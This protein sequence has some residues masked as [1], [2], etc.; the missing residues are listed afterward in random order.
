M[1]QRIKEIIQFT[2]DKFG[3]EDYYLQS[4]SLNRHV[5]I[6]NETEYTLCMEWFPQHT[7][8]VEEGN[9]PDGAAMIEIDVNS[10]KIKSATF[11]NGKTYAKDGIAFT[12]PYVSDM[13]IWIEKEQ[14]ITYGTQFETCKEEREVILFTECLKGLAVYPPGS[15]EIKCDGEGKLTSLTVQG[16]FPSMEQVMDEGYKLEVEKIPQLKWEQIKLMDFPLSDQKRLVPIYAVEEIYVMNSPL[17]TIAHDFFIEISSY[18]EINQILEWEEPIHRPYEHGVVSWIEEITPEQAFA[19]E[20]APE[21]YPITKAEQDQCVIAIRDFLRKV[22]PKESGTWKVN[23]LF[24]DKGYIHALLQANKPTNHL[25]E[26][27]LKVI[28]LAESFEVVNY[29]DNKLLLERQTSLQLPGK[30]TVAKEEAYEKLKDQF[31]LKPCYVYDKGQKKYFLGGKLDCY[32]G[33][34]AVTGE[35]VA[36]DDLK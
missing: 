7:T 23:S 18:T 4:H 20:A 2:N 36:M 29:I 14:G 12:K 13:I 25:F 27:K 28:I 9:T 34:H 8:I 17:R 1:H 10:H 30:I 35:L 26:R 3:L 21:S 6:F 32:Y 19:R 5:N 11:V 22:Y 15:I 33:V 24:R 16:H 31:V